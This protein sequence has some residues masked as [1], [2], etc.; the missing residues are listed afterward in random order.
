LYP[1]V[2]ADTTIKISD[3]IRDRLRTLA[4]ERGL[5]TRAYVERVVSGI[6]TEAERAEQTAKAIA[7]VRAH[8]GADI[9]D[10]DLRR[11]REWRQAVAAG[12]V[13]SR[14]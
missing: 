7:Y 1:C 2:M 4:E 10:E 9:T 6:P 5:S 14:R 3:E 8:F 12:R 13:G 11:G